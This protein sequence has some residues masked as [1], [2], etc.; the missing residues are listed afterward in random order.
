VILQFS[1]LVE[2]G[3]FQGANVGRLVRFHCFIQLIHFF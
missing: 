2:A 3:L 1:E